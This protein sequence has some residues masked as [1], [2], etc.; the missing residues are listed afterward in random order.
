[1]AHTPDDQNEN[2]NF[3]QSNYDSNYLNHVTLHLV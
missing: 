3:G 2:N 1:M